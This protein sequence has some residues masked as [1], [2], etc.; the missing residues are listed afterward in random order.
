MKRLLLASIAALLLATGTAHAYDAAKDYRPQYESRPWEAAPNPEPPTRPAPLGDTGCVSD[1]NP[2]QNQKT[3]K[4]EC[5]EVYLPKWFEKAEAR[6]LRQH[7]QNG[8]LES[9]KQLSAYNR[10]ME[11]THAAF[12]KAA[13]RC[14]RQHGI[15]A[16]NRCI[17][18]SAAKPVSSRPAP[19]K[20]DAKH[21]LVPAICFTEITN[22]NAE[23][24]FTICGDLSECVDRPGE[25]EEL[26]R[27]KQAH[28]KA[29]RLV[30]DNKE[31]CKLRDHGKAYAEKDYIWDCASYRWKWEDREFGRRHGYKTLADACVMR[32]CRMLGN[33]AYCANGNVGYVP[34]KLRK[35]QL[36]DLG[37]IPSERY[38]ERP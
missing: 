25:C 23:K 15:S 31:K 2:M 4:W 11:P 10:C 13:D 38:V 21:S 6:C 8:V 16:Y 5:T 3:G 1:A 9:P 22:Q 17:E 14:E 26:E 27:D 20:N 29:G 34:R 7:A 12:K 36:R 32:R 30:C 18:K 24:L 33:W 37:R 19:K 35:Q 28:I